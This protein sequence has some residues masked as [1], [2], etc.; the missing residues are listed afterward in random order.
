MNTRLNEFLLLKHKYKKNPV[1]ELYSLV[2]KI[3]KNLTNTNEENKKYYG[4]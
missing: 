3:R 4:K 1:I 2:L